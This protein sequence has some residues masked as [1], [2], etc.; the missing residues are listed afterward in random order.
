MT[1]EDRE[2]LI[3]DICGRLRSWPRIVTND[4]DE[5]YITGVDDTVDGIFEIHILEDGESYDTYFDVENFKLCLRPMDSMT[6]E[7]RWEL[8]GLSNHRYRYYLNLDTNEPELTLREKK[9]FGYNYMEVLEIFDWLNKKRFD[10]RGLIPK[11]LAIPENEEPHSGVEDNKDEGESMRDMLYTAAKKLQ[12][13]ADS[14]KSAG[15]ELKEL[16]K[17]EP[18]IDRLWRKYKDL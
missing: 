2:L 9:G 18:A 5:G 1:K 15:R 14:L 6:D 11:G 8:E 4:G 16:E 17:D 12:E 13:I 7:E 10:Y 3:T